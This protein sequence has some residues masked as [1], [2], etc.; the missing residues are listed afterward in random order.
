MKHTKQNS[1]EARKLFKPREGTVA[2][3]VLAALNEGIYLTR[4][5]LHEKTGIEIAT[6][7]GALDR[8]IDG[9]RVRQPFSS[10]CSKTGKMVAVYT[11][12]SDIDTEAA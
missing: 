1:A 8:L 6:L 7:C 9:G 2:A 3:R 10:E 4:R 11:F 12:I 5:E